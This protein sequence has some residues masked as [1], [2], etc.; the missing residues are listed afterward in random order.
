MV[1]GSGVNQT[2]SVTIPLNPTRI[3]SIESDP[4]LQQ[5]IE[6]LNRYIHELDYLGTTND[7]QEQTK[8]H[9]FSFH[10]IKEEYMAVTFQQMIWL[11][12]GMTFGQIYLP[13]DYTII[14]NGEI[15]PFSYSID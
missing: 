11:V 3:R 8:T 9:Y 13:S 1:S 14:H 15:I 5:M 10:S 7:T 6:Q 4:D 2:F 12:T